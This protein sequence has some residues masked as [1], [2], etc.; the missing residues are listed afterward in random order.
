MKRWAR[1][2]KVLDEGIDGLGNFICLVHMRPVSS[3]LHDDSVVL[4]SQPVINVAHPWTERLASLE[5][6]STC[7]FALSALYKE[8]PDLA[9]PDHLHDILHAFTIPADIALAEYLLVI[10]I[11]VTRMLHHL[12]LERLGRQ[13]TPHSLQDILNNL[14]LLF[15]GLA[16]WSVVLGIRAIPAA[17]CQDDAHHIGLSLLEHLVD[18]TAAHTVAD[19]DYS[20][21]MVLIVNELVYKHIQKLSVRKNTGN[22]TDGLRRLAMTRQVWCNVKR[23]RLTLDPGLGKT[24]KQRLEIASTASPTMDEQIQF[25]DMGSS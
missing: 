10:Q 23:A 4:R 11:K 16:H 8:Y 5:T 6:M 19:E 12:R 25:L 2:R 14:Q 7:S 3:I 21:V 17:I 15:S 1:S 24:H 9:S 22:R 18:N 20:Y 13:G